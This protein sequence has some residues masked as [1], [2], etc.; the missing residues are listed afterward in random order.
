VVTNNNNTYVCTTSHISTASFNA[1][2]WALIAAQG[3][4]GPTGPSGAMGVLTIQTV[5]GTT[6]TV[7]TGNNAGL[8]RFTTAASCAVS[9]PVLS[10][11]FWAVFKNDLASGLITITPSGTTLDGVAS[12]TIDPN[13]CALIA[14]NGTNYETIGG[15]T[16][17]GRF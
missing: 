13:T 11:G 3:P 8:I 10:T 17:G 16:D 6:Y 15:V 5:T 1:A 12:V 2:F 7:V 9:L 4:I 14:Y